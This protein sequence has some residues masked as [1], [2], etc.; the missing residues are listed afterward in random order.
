MSK[1]KKQQ[2]TEKEPVENIQEALTKSEQFIEKNQKIL[3]YTLG[4]ILAVILLVWGYF[5]FVKEP[6][7]QKAFSVMFVAERN[8]ERDSFNLA[9]NGSEG[10]PGFLQIIDDYKGTKAANLAYFYA[11]VSYMYLEDYDNAI[12]YLK[13]FETDDPILATEKYGAIADA[14]VNKGEYEQAVKFYK[15]ATDAKYKNDFTTPLYLK[16]LG[17]VY[18]KLQKYDNALKAYEEIYYKFPF[19]TEAA[20]IERYIDRVKLNIK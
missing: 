16:K 3:L 10:Y 13:K 14:Y 8:F 5:K 20:T 7:E 2:Q 11:G 17:L 18:E 1:K 19:S 9:L 12:N 4:G 15:K 6:R